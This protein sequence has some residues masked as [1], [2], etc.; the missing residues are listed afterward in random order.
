MIQLLKR[1]DVESVSDDEPCCVDI[2]EPDDEPDGTRK[3]RSSETDEICWNVDRCDERSLPLDGDYCPP[4][5]G[6][7]WQQKN[8][9]NIYSANHQIYT[10]GSR[11][12]KDDISLC[13][14]VVNAKVEF[15]HSFFTTFHH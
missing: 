11:Q 12:Y 14:C 2:L 7:K 1:D 9:N 8:Y 15:H 6:N 3:R 13:W 5:Q 4:V 10:E